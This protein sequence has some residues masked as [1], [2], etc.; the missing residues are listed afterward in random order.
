MKNKEVLVWM[1][2]IVLL[3]GCIEKGP[4]MTT[5]TTQ[6][7]VETTTT[8]AVVLPQRDFEVLLSLDKEVYY[9]NEEMNISVKVLSSEEVEGARINLLGIY[10]T[11]ERLNRKRIV[12]LQEG[13]NEFYFSYTTPRCYGC[14]GI[15]QGFYNIT[16]E[17]EYMG[18]VRASS[19]LEVE[20]RE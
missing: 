6:G 5:T 18:K 20:I 10:S 1:L 9:S 17:L 11:R 19:T 2:L 8:L 16:S 12:E 7:I 15:S 4:E 3:S 14:A 13:E